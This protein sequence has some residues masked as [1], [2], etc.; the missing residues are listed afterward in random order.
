MED[1]NKSTKKN[2]LTEGWTDYYSNGP[3]TASLNDDDLSQCEDEFFPM[4]F[5][6]DKDGE[7][8]KTV[9]GLSNARKYIDGLVEK[10]KANGEP[11]ITK[12]TK[13]PHHIYFYKGD[14]IDPRYANLG[15]WTWDDG[16]DYNDYTWVALN[17][18]KLDLYLTFRATFISYGVCEW[19]AYVQSTSLW[20]YYEQ[21]V[22]GVDTPKVKYLSTFDPINTPPDIGIWSADGVVFDFTLNTTSP[23]E[24]SKDIE[25]LLHDIEKNPKKYKQ[26]IKQQ[27]IDKYGIEIDIV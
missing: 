16:G 11:I 14:A 26:Q 13:F 15:G 18:V 8:I 1:L 7:F 17:H 2:V 19:S 10:D 3:Y 21:S 27:V 6:I 22:D 25:R 5:K 4:N 23:R 20:D 24:V 9:R 12:S